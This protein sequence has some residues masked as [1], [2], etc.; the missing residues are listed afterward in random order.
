LVYGSK[1]KRVSKS[2]LGGGK[3]K[4]KLIATRIGRHGGDSAL[5]VKKSQ[6]WNQKVAIGK[7]FRKNRGR[8]R[9][10]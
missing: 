9:G 6:T 3:I 4:K 7:G 10:T 1:K 5:F 8:C 2:S